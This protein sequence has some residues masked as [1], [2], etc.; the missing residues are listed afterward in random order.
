MVDN[1]VVTAT[2]ANFGL[3]HVG[4]ALSQ[5]ITLSTTG[6]DNH[7]TRVT[8]P[9]PSAPDANGMSITGGANPTFN[10]PAISDTP[11][12]FRRRHHARHSQWYD[13]PRNQR[14][15]SDGREACQR[16]GELFRTGVLGQR[17][18][19]QHLGIVLEPNG[20]WTDANGSGVQA[21]PGSFAGFNNTDTAVFSGSGSVTAIDLTG[22]NPSLNALSFSNSS[23]TLS[24]GSLTLN[25]S[26]GTATVTVSS[27]TQIDQHAHN[28]CWQRQLRD[29]R[30]G[31][32]LE[33]HDQRVGRVDKERF[34]RGNVGGGRHMEFD[35]FDRDYPGH[36]DRSVGH[37]A[38]WRWHHLGFRCDL[39]G[40]A[41][42]S[43]GQWRELEP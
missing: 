19:E 28:A 26:T 17:H 27:G 31:L 21:A 15:G 18:M 34:R 22:A 12:G 33:L 23:Y 10:G 8:V 9:N 43:I 14:R 38:R 24:N 7:Y 5:G 20:N 37:L 29:Q 6:D 4:A 42:R 13:H 41:D 2:P 36:F 11:H 1:R 30:R 32:A 39:A 3:V 16:A 35:R 25:G 40:R